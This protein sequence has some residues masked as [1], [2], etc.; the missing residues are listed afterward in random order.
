MQFRQNY[1]SSTL[2]PSIA[3]PGQIEEPMG[4]FVITSA[5][6]SS[7]TLRADDDYDPKFLKPGRHY[8]LRFVGSFVT[9]NLG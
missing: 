8:Q 1:F 9:L 3:I 7:L 2:L 6:S 5:Y 4:R